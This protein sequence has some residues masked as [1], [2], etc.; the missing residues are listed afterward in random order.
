MPSFD[1]DTLEAWRQDRLYEA[2]LTRAPALSEHQACTLGEELRACEEGIARSEAR[3]KDLRDL[4]KRI[5]RK[6]AAYRRTIDTDATSKDT[7]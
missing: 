7:P 2:L 3:L 5:A 4:R 6:L 1:R